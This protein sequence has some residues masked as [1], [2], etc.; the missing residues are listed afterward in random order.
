MGFS[1]YYVVLFVWFLFLNSSQAGIYSGGSGTEGSPYMISSADDWVE[2]VNTSGDWSKQ[3]ILTSHV[4]LADVPD[5]IP[6][7]IDTDSEMPGYQGT[8]FSGTFNGRGYSIYNA[9]INMPDTDRVGIFG[10]LNYSGKIINLKVRSV[11]ITGKKD[12]GG[13]VAENYGLIEN[14]YITGLVTGDNNVGGMTAFNG[15]TITNSNANVSVTGSGDFIGGLVGQMPYTNMHGNVNNCFAEGDVIGSNYVGGLVGQIRGYQGGDAFQYCYSTG[16]VTGNQCVGGLAGIIV[17][18]ERAISRCYSTSSVNGVDNVGGL[19]GKNET[20]LSYCGASGPV[21]GTGNNVGGLTGSNVRDIKDCYA[22]GSV[23]GSDNVGGLSG[24]HEYGLIQDCYSISHV[25]GT[26]ENTGS[27]IGSCNREPVGCYWNT[28][29]SGISE[30]IGNIDPDPAGVI[31][32]STYDM[33]NYD[34]FIAASWDFSHYYDGDV[35]AWYMPDNDYPRL[36][37]RNGIGSTKYSGGKGTEDSP[38]IIA[39]ASDWLELT[40]R[41]VDWSCYFEMTDNID[42]SDAVDLMPVAPYEYTEY[43]NYFVG[44]FTGVLDGNGYIIYNAVINMPQKNSIGL[45]REIQDAKILNLGLVNIEISGDSHVGGLV[46]SSINSEIENCFAIGSVNCVG[47]TAGGLIGITIDGSVNNCYSEGSVTGRYDLG[48]LIGENNSL[49]SNSYFN[50]SIEGMHD[51]GGLIAQ[52][53]GQVNNCYAAGN[54]LVSEF[55]GGGLICSCNADVDSCYAAFTFTGETESIGG[56]FGYYTNDSIISCYWDTE[57]SG[58]TKVFGNAPADITLDG[59]LGLISSDMYN[60]NTFV[61]SGWD[62]DN[63]WRINGSY[64]YPKLTWQPFGDLNNDSSVDMTDFVTLSNVWQTK[65]IEPGWN[66]NY[67]LHTDGVIDI[68]D[69]LTIAKNW[70]T[71]TTP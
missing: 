4:D 35:A 60:K 43:G 29:T 52:S 32:S 65:A 27:L 38:Y 58:T 56:L 17:T 71:G 26:G 42:L 62:F 41:S 8:G 50:G 22:S 1:R 15:G 48:G 40:F 63:K 54:I 70:L 57:L 21:T 12:V 69:L 5:L 44:P 18:G 10:Y 9:T 68:Q 25:E 51:I 59:A 47:S 24:S 20:S 28:E 66:H 11:N 7:G 13:L 14:C 64:D 34:T 46:G 37:W 3:F 49:V 16:T 30:G 19:I 55:G 6:V 61:D 45:F 23:I 39:V 67:D 53:Y 2:F 36:A 33:H 31:A